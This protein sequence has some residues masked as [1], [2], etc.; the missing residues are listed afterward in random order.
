MV[1]QPGASGCLT[2]AHVLL[3][4]F[5]QDGS[6]GKAT[7]APFHVIPQG[8]EP[9]WIVVGDSRIGARVLRSWRPYKVSTRLRWS[10]VVAAASVG[11]LHRLPGVVTS[12]VGIDFSYWRRTLA[13]F[14]EDGVA[15]L[16]IG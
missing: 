10:A 13:G 8:V 15:V 14:E 5:P 6:S 7:E 9:R 11:G 16:Y 3:T 4:A 12:R 1:G 2:A